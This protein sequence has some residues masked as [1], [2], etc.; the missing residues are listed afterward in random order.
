M[1]QYQH[2]ERIVRV[3]TRLEML[4]E[5]VGEVGSKVDTLDAKLDEVLLQL[6]RKPDSEAPR[7]KGF[8][9]SRGAI[10]ALAA[11]IGGAITAAV[12]AFIAG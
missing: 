1:S 11:L 12:K 8:W 9:I 4:S 6:A 3:E 10:G 7:R 5:K 2:G